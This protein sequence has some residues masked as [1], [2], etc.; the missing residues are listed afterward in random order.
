MT[1]RLFITG[2][3]TGVGKTI[4]TATFGL[5]LQSLGYS[6]RVF[7][8]FES[9]DPSDSSPSDSV[10]LKTILALDTP[11]ETIAPYRFNEPLAPGIAAL[12]AHILPSLDTVKS[13][14]NELAQDC[15]YLLIEGAGGLYVPL[16]TK[17]DGSSF[18]SIDLISALNARAVL[19]GRLGLGTL[20][21]TL[22]S[23]NALKQHA[24]A[25][26]GIILN[27]TTPT[28]GLAEQTNPTALRQL[29]GEP[30]PI[31]IFPHLASCTR[32]AIFVGGRSAFTPEWINHL[33]RK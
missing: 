17:Q 20:N 15:D 25:R 13:C 14:A 11:I 24:I 5:H 32:E 28:F 9:N 6:V 26:S 21:H 27:T 31:A 2:T 10:F 19:V 4:I 1:N 22:L 7:K 8:P 23:I 3:D 33:L 16:F 30:V 12:R 18:F 29:L